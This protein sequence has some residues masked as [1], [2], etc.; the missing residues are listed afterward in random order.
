MSGVEKS[1]PLYYVAVR[2]KRVGFFYFHKITPFK[3]EK[4]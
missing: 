2:Y 4:Q 1:A 3:G